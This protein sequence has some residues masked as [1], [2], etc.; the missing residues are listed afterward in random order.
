VRLHVR[1]ALRVTL[2][3]LVVAIA[4][5]RIAAPYLIKRYVNQELEQLD[6][7]TGHVDDVDLNLWRG[8]YEVEGVRI[9]KT[10]GHVPVPF[11]ALERLD[12]SVQWRAL[13]HGEVVAKVAMFRPQVNF[14]KGPTKAQTQTGE[15]TDWRKTLND[16][17]PLRID[18]FTVVDGEVHYRDLHAQ[19]KVDVFVDHLNATVTNLTNSE[20]ISASR[21]A[22]LNVQADI[23]R[24]GALRLDGSIDPF[25]RRPTFDVR[26]RLEKLRIAKLNDFL[27]AY[28]DV[29]VEKGTLA[30]YSELH[31]QRGAFHGYVKPL[32][33]DLDV[34]DWPNEKER[35]L[36]KIWEGLVGG[37]AVVFKNLP[38]DQLGS[39]IPLEGEFDKPKVEGW[40]AL[41]SLLRNAF[42]RALRHGLE[43][44]RAG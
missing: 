26:T 38:H 28:L 16:I 11:V 29:D 1:T 33:E 19:P 20:Q 39:R 3:V 4:A 32:I 31:A 6:G 35:P 34:L 27:K 40:Q 18:R 17:V 21:V 43:T 13:L 30:L 42:V 10:G 37:V 23:M 22:R 24:S 14:V 9:D 41:V 5:A 2:V 44:T 12:L 25:A 7:Y 8:A 36:E 15:E